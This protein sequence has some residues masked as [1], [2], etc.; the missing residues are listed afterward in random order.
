MQNL[1]SRQSIPVQLFCLVAIEGLLC[2]QRHIS[3][4]ICKTYAAYNWLVKLRSSHLFFGGGKIVMLDDASIKKCL[5]H[6]RN[7]KKH[8]M[9]IYIVEALEW[10]PVGDI[11][12][13]ASH[14]W[15][16]FRGVWLLDGLFEESLL[17][18]LYF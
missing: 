1:I 9:I 8:L 7:C 13:S 11:D 2:S 15:S 6:A 12:W 16:K 14:K 18:N 10:A 4:N 3:R 17:I 5:T